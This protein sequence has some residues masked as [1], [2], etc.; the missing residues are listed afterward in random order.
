MRFFVVLS[1]LMLAYLALYREA[2]TETAELLSKVVEGGRS[3]SNPWIEIRAYVLMI[4]MS[5]QQGLSPD[6]LQA[7][8]ESVLEKI[9][10]ASGIQSLDTLWQAYR[11]K[12]IASL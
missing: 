3:M 12:L 5:K 6:G 2:Y 10:Q 8:L 9:G 7:E 11:R 4:R 1:D